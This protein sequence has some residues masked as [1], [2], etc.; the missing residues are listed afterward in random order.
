MEENDTLID[1]QVD[2]ATDVATDTKIYETVDYSKFSFL[3]GNRNINPNHLNRLK[4]SMV[5]NYLYTIILVNEK[6]EIIDG[7]HRFTVIKELGLLLNYIIVKNYG[8]KEVQVLNINTKNWS[9]SDYADGYAN[10][11][12]LNYQIYLEFKDKYEFN[13][14]VTLCLLNNSSACGKDLRNSFKG[15]N[16]IVRNIVQA[17]DIADKITQIGEFYD[18][19]K[20]R[21]FVFAMIQVLK[22]PEFVFDNFIAKLKRL[23]KKMIDCVSTEDYKELIEKIYNYHRK[24]KVNLRF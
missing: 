16:F 9:Q 2:V 17:S 23:Q 18:G 22:N 7:Q 6:Y 20:R 1:Q 24:N 8:L 15:G 19:H 14:E 5:N 21:T 11:G 3:D 4:E 13:H 12:N 10:L